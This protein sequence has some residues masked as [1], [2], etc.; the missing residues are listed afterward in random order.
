MRSLLVAGSIML[1]A[2]ACAPSAGQE[3]A[4]AT[5]SIDP[6]QVAA[7]SGDAQ[8]NERNEQ[9]VKGAPGVF[10]SPAPIAGP[11]PSPDDRQ[12]AKPDRR[13]AAREG[14][15]DQEQAA[16][17]GPKANEL[18]PG[19]AN[20][21]EDGSM[22]AYEL[23]KQMRGEHWDD[24]VARFEA[25]A[26]TDPDAGELQAMY[27]RKLRESTAAHG[28]ALMRFGCGLSLCAGTVRGSANDRSQIDHWWN[29]SPVGDLPAPM[30]VVAKVDDPP[31][32]EIR[33][34]FSTDQSVRSMIIRH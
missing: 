4:D 1:L 10:T 8:Q 32:V 5:T 24:A 34:S 25:D 26:M 13:E 27:E 2:T 17:T 16:A 21:F 6:V 3:S 7:A 20:F 18:A 9:G 30:R 33:F 14:E 29:G 12:D 11:V 23:R 15:V 31:Y 22:S 28:L 19:E